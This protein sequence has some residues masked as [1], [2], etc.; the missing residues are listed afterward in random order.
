MVLRFCV[1]SYCYEQAKILGNYAQRMSLKSD[2]QRIQNEC[3]RVDAALNQGGNAAI[4]AAG[5]AVI[6]KEY[7]GA[8]TGMMLTYF[9]LIYQARDSKQQIKHLQNN[10]LNLMKGMLPQLDHHTSLYNNDTASSAA[11]LKESFR[12]LSFH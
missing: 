12:I 7:F 2:D 1:C 6:T 3:A 10:L 11:D 5:F 9:I 8:I 4:S